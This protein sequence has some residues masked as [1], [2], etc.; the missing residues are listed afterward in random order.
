M[1]DRGS[2]MQFRNIEILQ[3]LLILINMFYY[4]ERKY[5]KSDF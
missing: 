4:F 2:F 5:K 3:K 1:A